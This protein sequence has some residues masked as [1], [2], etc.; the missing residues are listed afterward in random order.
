MEE[1]LRAMAGMQTHALD[2]SRSEAGVYLLR[3][4][5]KDDSRTFKVVKY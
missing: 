3:I 5:G 2:L 4:A 1:T